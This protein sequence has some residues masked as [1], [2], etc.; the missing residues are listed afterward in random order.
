[1]E[2]PCSAK[3]SFPTWRAR[4]P[5]HGGR[6]P[7]RRCRERGFSFIELVIVMVLLGIL[8]VIALPAY[9]EQIR[10]AAR[11]DA[12]AFL[13]DVASRQQQYL[14]DKRRYAASVAALNMAPSAHLSGKFENPIAVEA[15][16]VVPPTFRIIARAIGDQ[17]YDKCPTL[18]LDSAGNREPPGCW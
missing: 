17:A 18:T 9:R 13:T 6:L 14:V 15:P 5:C 10:K 3:H 4:F 8:A 1:V 11:A 2:H 12:Q 7:P 16:D